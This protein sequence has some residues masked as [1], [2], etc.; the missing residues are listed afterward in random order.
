MTSFC[1]P[2]IDTFD[3]WQH[4]PSAQDSGHYHNHLRS[5]WV[6]SRADMLIK[7]LYLLQS[8]H[9]LECIPIHSNVAGEWIHFSGHSSV[10]KGALTYGDGFVLIVSMRFDNI[11]TT[12]LPSAESSNT[13]IWLIAHPAIY[14][15]MLHFNR[16]DFI[17]GRH[18]VDST[19]SNGN[20]C[21][22]FRHAFDGIFDEMK[23]TKKTISHDRNT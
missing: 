8:W 3:W 20:W 11:F 23:E 10:F 18:F 15:W 2:S 9:M 1:K 16:P 22:C 19:D 13:S 7:D 4:F 12:F 5:Y 21:W 6:G 17:A 14:S